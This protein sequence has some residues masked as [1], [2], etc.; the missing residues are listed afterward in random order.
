MTIKFKGKEQ[1][2]KFTFNSFKYMTDFEISVFAEVEDK[3][4]KII[5]LLEMLLLGA[6][7]SN[8]KVIVDIVDVQEFLEEFVEDGEIGSLLEDLMQLLQDCNFFKS[9]QKKT[10]KVKK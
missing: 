6:L 3:P 9:L 2:L 10:K 5:P 8:S 4:F 7:N 1:E